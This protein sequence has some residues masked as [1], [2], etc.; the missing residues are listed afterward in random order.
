GSGFM[1]LAAE[2]QDMVV[3]VLGRNETNGEK[4]LNESIEGMPGDE[5]EIDVLITPIGTKSLSGVKVKNVLPEGISYIE[6]ADDANMYD[7]SV[8]AVDV[9]NIPLGGSRAIVIK[10]KIK[11]NDNF[12]YGE[13]VLEDSVSVSADNVATTEKGIDI[14]VSRTVE[15]SGAL[16]DFLGNNFIQALIFIGLIGLIIYLIVDRRKGEKDKD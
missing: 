15:A 4:F 13:A 7:G 10:G 3:E 2:T 12:S 9:G 1:A 5:I 8:L 6:M 16:I 14:S 11:A